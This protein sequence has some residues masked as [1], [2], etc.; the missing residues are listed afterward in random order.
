MR[1]QADFPFFHANQPCSE[2]MAEMI[3][4]WPVNR[5]VFA[6]SYRRNE[7]ANVSAISKPTPVDIMLILLIAIIWASAFVSIKLLVG[8]MGPLWAAASR[9]T[10]G[11]LAVL[12]FLFYT[13]RKVNITPAKLLPIGAVAMLNMVIPFILIS[14]SLTHIDTG[15]SALL[16]GTTP[17]IAMVMGHFITHD[18]RITIYS[19]LAVICGL[20]GI[21]LVV[22][23]DAIRGISTVSILAQLGIIGA[24]FCYVSAGFIMRKIDMDAIPFTGLALGIGALILMLIAF[25]GEG[26]PKIDLKYET[27][28]ALIW[29]G[30]FPTG[31]AYLLRY[32][33]VRKVGVSIFAVGMNTIPVFGIIFGAIILGETVELTTLI[34]LFLV[35]CGLF[36]ARL[37]AVRNA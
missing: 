17:F 1:K 33:L 14:W 13:V 4:K 31:L 3:L 11:F 36:I 30:T 22:G 7:P 28:I 6:I 10:V 34:A 37:G 35:V 18:E 12:P 8:E 19:I 32:Y 23:T 25:L 21:S 29:L 5:V 26:V 2:C 27:W 20:T 9:V 15:I 16:L 24:G